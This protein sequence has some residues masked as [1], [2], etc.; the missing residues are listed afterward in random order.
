MN[1]FYKLSF[2][3]S[4]KSRMVFLFPDVSDLDDYISKKIEDKKK[5]EQ[6]QKAKSLVKI[7]SCVIMSVSFILVERIMEKM[8]KTK[9]SGYALEKTRKE[10]AKQKKKKRKRKSKLGVGV[11]QQ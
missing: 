10:K 5:L 3:A 11:L 1:E 4:L 9:T 8:L 7:M 6:L 2:L